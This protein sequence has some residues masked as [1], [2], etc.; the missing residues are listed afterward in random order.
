VTATYIAYSFAQVQYLSFSNTGL[1]ASQH[2]HTP[3]MFCNIKY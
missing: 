1:V 3:I 2:T